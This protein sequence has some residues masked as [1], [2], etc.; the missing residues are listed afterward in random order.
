VVK[1]LSATGPVL[2]VR[3]GTLVAE[4][5]ALVRLLTEGAR[6]MT[7]ALNSVRARAEWDLRITA[8]RL[9]S[10]DAPTADVHLGEA[11]RPGAGANYLLHRR[12]SRREAEQLR[13]TLHAAMTA[14]DEGLSRVADGAAGF[15]VASGATTASCAYLV[16]ESAVDEFVGTAERGIAELEAIGCTVLLRG[17]L[18][19]Y[20]FVDIRLEAYRNA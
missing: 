18:P 8:P 20:S 10:G 15:R 16:H 9:E 13:E 7:D 5:A 1:A 19:P 3:L 17:P 2:P 4:H 6:S 12:D 14:L 11:G